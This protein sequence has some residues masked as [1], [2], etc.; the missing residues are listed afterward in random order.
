MALTYTLIA[1]NTVG[2]TP[3]TSVTLS[4]IPST[5]TDLLVKFSTR[6]NDNVNSF[7]HIGMRFNGDTGTNYNYVILRGDGSGAI[8]AAGTIAQVAGGL[9]N[10][11][12]STANTFGSGEFYIPNY[13]G[14]NVKS[15]SLE[16][17]NETNSAT[18]YMQMTA[19]RWS[20]TAAI[21][22]ITFF[23]P[24]TGNPFIQYS[25]FYIYGIKNS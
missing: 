6:T 14:S 20:G 11:N 25:S 3:V 17:V 8:S 1:S 9:G 7:A 10:G 19:T 2:S 22:S 21:T 23:D 15:L 4:S 5:Y 24:V 16:S 13:A 12:A 18:A